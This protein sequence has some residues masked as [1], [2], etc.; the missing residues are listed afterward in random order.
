MQR[1]VFK[2][3]FRISLPLMMGSFLQMLYN[4]TDAFFLGKL[5]REELSAPAIVMTLIMFLVMFGMGL[6][7]AGTTLIS[8]AKGKGD[9]AR[10]DFT[11][12]NAP[13]SSCLSR[14]QLC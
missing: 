11:S 6:S 1:S 5:G 9:Q 3:L 10:V 2:D 7:V 12:D 14:Y 8:Q 4:L 13:L